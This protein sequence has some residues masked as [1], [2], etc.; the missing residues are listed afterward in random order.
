MGDGDMS[1]MLKVSPRYGRRVVDWMRRRRCRWADAVIAV[2]GK[3]S[4][5]T[6]RLPA[7]SGGEKRCLL[8][9]CR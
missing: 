3:V 4:G 5:Q 7:A 9:T 6:L 1:L 2:R 8:D